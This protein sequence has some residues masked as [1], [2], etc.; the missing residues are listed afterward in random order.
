MAAQPVCTFEES[1]RITREHAHTFYFASHMLPREKREAAYAVYAF[2]RHADNLVD[3]R[4]GETTLA[5]DVPERL[6]A[7]RGE[8]TDMYEGAA[9][10]TSWPALQAVIRR[11]QIPRRY[12]DALIDGVEMDLSPRV[13]KTFAELDV[14]CYRVASVVG[15]IMSHVFGATSEEA[16]RDAAYLG[17]AMQLTNILRDVG[18]DYRLGRI[19]LPRDEMERFGVGERIIAEGVVTEDVRRLLEFQI[20]RAREY[21]RIAQPGI[22][23]LPND[24]S[25]LC[26]RLMSTLYARILDAI[27]DN[28][29]NVFS[30]RAHVPFRTKCRVALSVVTR[31]SDRPSRGQGEA[32]RR[33]G[34]TEQHS[35]NAGPEAT[36]RSSKSMRPMTL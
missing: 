4:G 1:R 9:E 15:L 6:A 32:L 10:T 28:G 33:D 8:L 29:Y 20:A 13:F 30:R 5:P 2:C 34:A 27:E 23:L 19:Y 17:T 24:G 36:G 31:L 18:E 25:Q 16:L 22:A 21:Y 26:V 14:Y 35:G 3:V 12:F 11:H 7:L